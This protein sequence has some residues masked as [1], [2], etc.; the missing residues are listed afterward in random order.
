MKGCKIVALGVA[1]LEIGAGRKEGFM[2]LDVLTV[3]HIVTR[4]INRLGMVN[5]TYSCTI[6]SFWGINLPD[7]VCVG[8]QL[9]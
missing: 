6:N 1:Y 3:H 5:R 9:E 8:M 7:S 4:T 2:A